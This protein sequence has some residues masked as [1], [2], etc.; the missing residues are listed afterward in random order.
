MKKENWGKKEK[1]KGGRKQAQNRK[2]NPER[3][4][5]WTNAKKAFEVSTPNN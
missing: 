2:K 3:E 5:R 1:E 4:T